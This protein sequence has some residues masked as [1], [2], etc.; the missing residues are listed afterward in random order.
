M[1]KQIFN[2]LSGNFDSV[3]DQ[4]KEIKYAPTTSTDWYGT[5]PAEVKAAL[6]NLANRT[7]GFA[8]L[9]NPQDIYVDDVAGDNTF[10]TGGIL[11]P[12]KSFATA[13]T[14]VTDPSKQYVIHLAP[15]T[16]PGGPYTVPGNVSIVGKQAT[17]SGS[18]Q[19][20]ADPGSVIAPVYDGVNLTISIGLSAAA[21]ALPIFQNAEFNITRTDIATGPRFIQIFNSSVSNLDVKGNIAVFNSLFTG[22]CTIKNNGSLVCDACVIGISVA[23]EELATISLVTCTFVGSITGTTVGLDTSIVKA[24]ATSLSFGG[25]VT[26]C[27]SQYIDTATNVGYTP[28]IPANWSTVPTTVKE[29]L[30]TL[31]TDKFDYPT[32]S[33]SQYIRGDGSLANFVIPPAAGSS[34]S[35]YLNGGVSQ[36]TFGGNTYYQMSKTAN[37]GAGADFTL[38]NTSNT[39]ARFITDAADPALLSIPAGSWNF[40]MYFS[41]SDSNQNPSFYVELYKYDGA[42]FSL[43]SS[44]SATPEIISN[45]TSIDLYSTS[46]TIPSS[47]TLSLTDRLAIVVHVNTDGNRTVTFH[48]QDSHLDQVVTTFSTGI[49]ALNGLTAQVQTFGTGTS[50]TDFGISSSSSSHT[51]NLPTASATNRGAL[52]S[53]D[54]STFN[55]K[56]DSASNVGAGSGVFKQK[57]GTNLEFKSVVAGTSITVTPNANDVTIATT[58]EANTASNVGA[59]AGV[60]KAKSGVDLQF[61]SLVQGTGISV[62]PGT[63]DVTIAVNSTASTLPYT[64]SPSSRWDTVPT[65]ISGALDTEARIINAGIKNYIAGNSDFESGADGSVPSGYAAYK[66]TAS[67]IPQEGGTGGSPNSTFTKTTLLPLR[68]SGSGLLTKNPGA[69]RQGEG[70]SYDF[71]IDQADKAKIL[72]I[73]FDYSTSASYV[74]GDIR[75]YVY[76]VTNASLIEVIDRDLPGNLQGQYVGSFQTNSNSIS[77]RLIWHIATA[78]DSNWTLTIDAVAVRSQTLIKGPIVTD[79]QSYTPTFTGFG[80]VSTQSFRYRRVGASLEIEGRFTSGTPTATEARITLPTGLTSAS[81]YVTLEIAGKS[82]ANVSNQSLI[83][84]I[85]PSITYLTFG[86]ANSTNTELVKLNATAFSGAGSLL[87]IRASVRIAGWSSNQVLSEDTG[88]RLVEFIAKGT[89]QASGTSS[90]NLIFSTV[91]KDSTAA[92]STV[93]GGYTVPET[94]YYSMSGIVALTIATGNNVQLYV[95]G[96]LYGPLGIVPNTNFDAPFSGKV[97]ATKG[98]VLS[99]RMSAS[100]TSTSS[101]QTWNIS[102]DSSPQTLAG[103]E[104]VAAMYTSSTQTWTHNAAPVSYK[105]P[106]L[107]YDTH[108]AYSSS[109]GVFTVPVSGKYYVC[110]SYAPAANT[111]AT[112]ANTGPYAQIFKNGAAVSGVGRVSTSAA[113]TFYFGFAAGNFVTASKGDTLEIR[114]SQNSGVSIT[115]GGTFE[116]SVAFEKVG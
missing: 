48:T 32:G 70:F 87:S 81:D 25:I 23:M 112:S 14:F 37:T 42:T 10:G 110:H 50:G 13:L 79:W 115:S 2:P 3:I 89:I 73:S 91:I 11:S 6:D 65:T 64:P 9:N 96:V 108:N 28:A 26:G 83:S 20:I 66:N 98:Q 51:F 88:N 75:L 67:A 22:T 74:D 92:Y 8:A 58:A 21:V 45:G 103:S 52:S 55:G 16:Y 49:S 82:A 38:T 95:D 69:S 107:V 113:T 19:V 72:R 39:M 101:Y 56:V 106:T 46:I 59:G 94:G 86:I 43:I 78:V 12:V 63:N 24:D 40:N 30:D 90:S 102:K 93:T 44:S 47:T 104:T 33:S 85:E 17:L 5:I 116:S 114:I 41:S 97:Y 53:S 36:G 1:P 109:T 54:W 111:A 34:V 29:G 77:Y 80:T 71:T 27:V 60:F 18:I 57:T 68:N 7:H 76:D 62:T 100:W 61:K 31:E 99:L 15:G 84:L 105:C 35:Y 4:A